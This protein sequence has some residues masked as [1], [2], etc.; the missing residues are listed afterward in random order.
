VSLVARPGSTNQIQ[1]NADTNATIG[2][3][4]YFQA[5]IVNQC[6]MLPWEVL[7]DADVKDSRHH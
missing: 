4:N 6:S 2:D 5:E 7:G 3:I 1:E